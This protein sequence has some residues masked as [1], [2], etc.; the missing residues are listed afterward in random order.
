MHRIINNVLYKNPPVRFY[1]KK[2]KRKKMKIRY[3]GQQSKLVCR[4]VLQVD[5]RLNTIHKLSSGLSATV[6][7]W[8][9]GSGWQMKQCGIE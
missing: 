6:L 4:P 7:G 5:T 1:R 2:F 9:P 3:L 8:I